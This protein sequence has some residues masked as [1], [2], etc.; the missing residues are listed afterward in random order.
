MMETR[1]E[2]ITKANPN[3]T[4]VGQG[5]AG[6]KVQVAGYTVP[7]NTAVGVPNGT[8]LIMKL[9]DASGNEISRD[10]YVFFYVKRSGFD[11]ML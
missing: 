8:Q 4:V 2:T 10:S 5:V 6:R 1:K 9:F 7:D 11:G 3:F